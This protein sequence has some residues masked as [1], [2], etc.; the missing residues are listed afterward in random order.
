MSAASF[1]SGWRS[2]ARALAR[3][4]LAKGFS[5]EEL[6]AAGLT[7]PARGRLLPAPAAL[8][9]RRRTRAGGRLP[10][11]SPARGRSAAG[12][13]REH[14]ASPSSSTRAGSSTASTTHAPRLQRRTAPCV[15]EGNTD[16][17]ALRQAGFEPV[18]ACMG[19]ALTE[20]QLKELGRLTKRLWLAFDGDAAGESATLARHGAR[21]AAGLRR[22]G[23]AAPSRGRPG[24]RP[25][26][27]RGASRCGRAVSRLPRA[28]RDRARRGSRGRV[29]DREGAARV[30]T[31]LAGAAGRL[32]LRQRQARH[33]RAA[34]RRLG[35]GA[36]CGSRDPA[37]ARRER[38]ARAERAARASSRTTG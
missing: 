5:H 10:G 15:V 20:Q 34:A 18:V 4:A 29:Q 37:R 21:G 9:A 14:A 6:R 33:D 26:G 16:V 35:L 11:P 23:R 8:P 1:G 30:G 13:I 22:E 17:L 7:R 19:T 38:E 28:H 32:A 25:D 3:K 24:G 27:L 12:E 36:G 2:A 31:G